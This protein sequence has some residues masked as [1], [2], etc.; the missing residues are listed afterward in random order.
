M[1][2]GLEPTLKSLQVKRRQVLDPSIP[3]S[4][5]SFNKKTYSLELTSF[6]HF[7][8]W[9]SL[10][11]QLPTLESLSNIWMIGNDRKGAAIDKD[12]INSRSIF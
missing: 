1:C 9:Y 12:V 4:R 8:C 3:Y 11:G 10:Y 6:V 2:D 5:Y 7:G